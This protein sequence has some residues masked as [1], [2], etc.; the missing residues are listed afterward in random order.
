MR[1][2]AGE[3]AGG[4]RERVWRERKGQEDSSCVGC[5]VSGGR[6]KR[7]TVEVR[8]KVGAKK[9]NEEGGRVVP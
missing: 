4:G 6:F 9:W 3:G 2:V 1:S 7:E 8:R 5:S